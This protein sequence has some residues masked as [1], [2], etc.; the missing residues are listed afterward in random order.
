MRLLRVYSA[1]GNQAEQV[2]SPL[3]TARMFHGVEQHRM[4]EQFTILDHQVDTGDVH[5]HD[6]SRANVEMPDLT[7]SHLPFRQAHERPAGMNEGIGIFAQQPVVGRL[8]R[9][10]DGVGF[11]FGSVSPA[12]ENRKNKWFRTRHE[13]SF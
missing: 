4:L 13:I 6:P 11:G 1:I 5:V 8:A 7:V 2:Q 9:E 3:A 12:V 10:G